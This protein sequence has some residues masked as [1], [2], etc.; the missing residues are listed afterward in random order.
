M[1]KAAVAANIVESTSSSNL[2][3]CL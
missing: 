1:R 3:L 2:L